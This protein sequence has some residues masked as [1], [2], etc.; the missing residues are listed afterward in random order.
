MH[1]HVA[2]ADVAAVVA[3]EVDRRNADRRSYVQRGQRKTVGIVAGVADAEEARD[4]VV[5]SN[6]VRWRSFVRRYYD[7]GDDRDSNRDRFR[8]S[9]IAHA[10]TIFISG[11][12]E[13]H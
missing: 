8:D 7:A 4:L 1:R 2:V 11:R 9:V 12:S 6:G 13:E 3:I 10:G 5:W